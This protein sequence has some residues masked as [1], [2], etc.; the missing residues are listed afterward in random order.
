M[1][2]VLDSDRFSSLTRMLRVLDSDRFSSLTRMLRALDS[3]R[4]QVMFRYF[5]DRAIQKDKSGM[6]QC[7]IAVGDKVFEVFLHM[8]AEK[9]KTKAHE[10]ELERHAQF[11]LVN[12]NHVH[13]RIRRVADK[14]LS[15]LAETFP[16]LLW[17]GRVLKTMLDILQTLSLSLSADIH[18]DQPYYDIPDTP[19]RITVPDTYEAREVGMC[20]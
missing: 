9:P 15:G 17:S 2:R 5:E 4:F 18:K 8:M 10:E 7:V 20:V 19:Y 6:M 16:H 1:L 11:L 12:F 3:D 14:Y 13:K